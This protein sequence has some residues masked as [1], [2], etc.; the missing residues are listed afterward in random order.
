MQYGFRNITP[1]QSN[2]ARRQLQAERYAQAQA[3]RDLSKRQR[4][5]WQVECLKCYKTWTLK[6]PDQV[7]TVFGGKCEACRDG[8]LSEPFQS[9]PQNGQRE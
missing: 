5:L 8:Q 1:R 2:E 9:D 6:D 3:L 4:L 7:S